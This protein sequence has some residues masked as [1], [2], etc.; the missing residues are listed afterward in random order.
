MLGVQE[1]LVKAR[2]L[3]DRAD[4]VSRIRRFGGEGHGSYQ[5]TGA[6]AWCHGPPLVLIFYFFDARGP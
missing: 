2:Q 1:E 4:P 6:L 5:A 3:G